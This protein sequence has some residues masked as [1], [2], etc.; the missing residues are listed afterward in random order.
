MDALACTDYGGMYWG[1]EFYQAAKKA[2]IKPILW[3]EL[4]YVWDMSRQEA[5]EVAGTIV[6]LARNYAWYEQLMKLISAAH[7]EWFHKIPRIDHACLARHA[8]ALT[9]IVWWDRSWL[10]KML[11]N[12]NE[13]SLITDQWKQLENTLWAEYCYLSRVAQ[14]KPEG[15][16]H[17]CN[18][19]IKQ[20]WTEHNI[21]LILSGDVHY[22]EA[23]D[24]Q[25]FETALAIK[26]GKRIYDTD[27]RLAPRQ[28]HLQ[29][30]DELRSRL[31]LTALDDEEVNAMIQTNQNIGDS[32]DLEIPMDKILFPIYESP[33]EIKNSYEKYQQQ[34]VISTV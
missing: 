4:G 13:Q 31:S 33:E 17:T 1:V 8:T 23:K 24:Q 14:E 20:F 25:I 6:L 18:E 3:V 12:K 15:G 2:G 22:K 32:I 5:N 34:L 30:E 27:R 11:V 7:L 28:M 21:S 10:G 16:L 9:C 19:L 26:D 29:T